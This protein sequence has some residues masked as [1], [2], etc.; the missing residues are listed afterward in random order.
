MSIIGM[1]VEVELSTIS[2]VNGSAFEYSGMSRGHYGN[3]NISCETQLRGRLP[4]GYHAAL[5]S[6]HKLTG[7]P[8]MSYITEGAVNPFIST[9]G[10][11][12][13][14]REIDLGVHGHLKTT[15]FVE[16]RG[17]GKLRAV[18]MDEGEVDVPELVAV[19]PTVETWVPAGPG[20]IDGA[21][22]FSWLSAEGA[23]ISGVARSKYTLPTELELP[24]I[25]HRDIRIDIDIPTD[26][27]YMNQKE[28]IVLFTPGMLNTMLMRESR[29][30]E[31]YESAARA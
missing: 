17:E 23:I 26:Q 31:Q 19:L 6:K 5:L 4:K 9:G 8:S 25:H 18:F 16:S 2:Q 13:A 24:G 22:T 3:G 14:T 30:V 21:M 15:Y 12:A 7:Q 28:R 10:V 29:E 11:Y 27:S 1:A 20:R